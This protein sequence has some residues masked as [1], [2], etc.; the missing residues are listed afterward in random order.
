MTDM[1]PASDA[2]IVKAERKYSENE[3]LRLLYGGSIVVQLGSQ[4]YPSVTSRK[5]RA[6]R[7]VAGCSTGARASAS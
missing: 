5:A 7:L 2:Q 1:G 6:A 3:P 4:L